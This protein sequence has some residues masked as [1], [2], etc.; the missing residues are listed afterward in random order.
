MHTNITGF[1]FPYGTHPDIQDEHPQTLWRCPRDSFRVIFRQVARPREEIDGPL[2]G[3][4]QVPS[5]R[6]NET[7][8]W[9][10]KYAT[11]LRDSLMF[12]CKLE[13]ARRDPQ[14]NGSYVPRTVLTATRLPFELFRRIRFLPHDLGHAWGW[15]LDEYKAEA[16]DISRDAVMPQTHL[17]QGNS[18]E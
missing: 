9:H 1:F 4:V 12:A 5:T 3:A 8:L 18:N 11:T 14:W 17:Y 16:D 7:G 10:G 2:I 15:D 6:P 13:V